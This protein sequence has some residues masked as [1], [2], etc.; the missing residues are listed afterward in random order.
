VGDRLDMGQY[1]LADI[2]GYQFIGHSLPVLVRGQKGPRHAA[3]A[4]QTSC[5]QR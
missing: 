5:S 1:E 3:L 2:E 4:R